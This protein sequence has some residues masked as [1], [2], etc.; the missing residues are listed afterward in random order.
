MGVL[1]GLLQV[2]LFGVYVW[3]GLGGYMHGVCMRL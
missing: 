2:H 1:G 3:G